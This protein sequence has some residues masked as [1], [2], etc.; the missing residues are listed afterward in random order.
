MSANFSP[1]MN[2]QKPAKIKEGTEIFVNSLLQSA[3][4]TKEV[5]PQ[6]RYDHVDEKALGLTMANLQKG[7][8]RRKL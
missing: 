8:I 3:Q 1:P 7:M 2:Q 5:K 4:E 6:T